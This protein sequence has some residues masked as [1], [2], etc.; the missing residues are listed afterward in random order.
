[1]QTS[2]RLGLAAATVLAFGPLANGGLAMGPIQAIAETAHYKLELDIGDSTTMYSKA[3]A[4]RL[5][6]TSGEIMV[7]GEMTG[8]M[9]AMQGMASSGSMASASSE[10]HLELHVLSKATGKVVQGAK[11]TIVAYGPTATTPIVVPIAVMYGVVQGEA[12]WHYG[13]NIQLA[14][15][16]YV[17]QVTANGE[18]AQFD[19]TVPAM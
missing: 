10:Q 5:K 1:M 14:P 13:N 12:D 2:S 15:G 17:V 4:Q 11:V 8:N 7:S 16:P 3:D 18:A 19:I 9:P 6:P